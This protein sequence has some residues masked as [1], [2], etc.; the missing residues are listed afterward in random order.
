MFSHLSRSSPL[1]PQLSSPPFSPLISVAEPFL[2]PAGSETELF[3]IASSAAVFSAANEDSAALVLTSS[4]CSSSTSILCCTRLRLFSMDLRPCRTRASRS[5]ALRLASSS[6]MAASLMLFSRSSRALPSAICSA[7]LTAAVSTAISHSRRTVASADLSSPRKL[8]TEAACE[9]SWPCRDLRSLRRS[10]NSSARAL[11]AA[12]A[13]VAWRERAAA[14]APT[15][16]GVEAADMDVL[17][18]C[19]PSYVCV[20]VEGGSTVVCA[21]ALCLLECCR[22][23]TCCRSSAICCLNSVSWALFSSSAE[24]S[25]LLD[26][27]GGGGAFRESP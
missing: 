16:R 24:V 6:A 4:S 12:A 15:D 2:K 19:R 27:C 1:P 18:L 17:W 20:G 10:W 7:C 14:P 9:D 5:R 13:A 3:N 25:V 22:L 26:T 11:S 23:S 8:S 21:W